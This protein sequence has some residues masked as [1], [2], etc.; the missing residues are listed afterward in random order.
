[1]QMDWLRSVIILT[2]LKLKGVS[3]TQFTFLYCA[4]CWI[5][6]IAIKLLSALESDATVE[7]IA[8]V[9]FTLVTVI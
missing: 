1:M 7:D 3:M 9:P 6:G 5:S 2:E 4:L 8:F